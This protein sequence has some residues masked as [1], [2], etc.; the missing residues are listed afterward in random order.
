MSVVSTS[1]LTVY[2]TGAADDAASS[3]T[4]TILAV[5]KSTAT[6]KTILNVSSVSGI[7]EGDI[8]TVASSGFTELDGYGFIVGAVD[9]TAKTIEVVGANTTN[10]T[11]TLSTSVTYVPT[12][13]VFKN[14]INTALSLATIQMTK[15]SAPSISIGTFDAP[16]ATIA[17]TS[18]SAGTATL[19]GF[20]DVSSA[21]YDAI[22]AAEADG[23]KRFLRIK[24]P[25]DGDVV[26][27]LI[28][29]TVTWD[30]PLSGAMGFSAACT[31]SLKP[32]HCF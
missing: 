10:S 19:T 4:T 20:V 5:T 32:L 15:D 17:G 26:V 27:P 3:T 6:T 13:K 29:S 7:T 28:I 21:S 23:L 12:L 8:M 11:N 24:L 2:L 9:G 14:S 18:T 22:Y 1:G 16:T 25:K 30:L 31:L